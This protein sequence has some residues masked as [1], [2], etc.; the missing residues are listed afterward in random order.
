MKVKL[1][2][3]RRGVESWTGFCDNCSARIFFTADVILDSE[4]YV[5]GIEEDSDEEDEEDEECEHLGA[6]G[7]CNDPEE[8]CEYRSEDGS[9]EHP[10]RDE[11]EDAGENADDPDADED[12]P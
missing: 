7:T 11:D 8:D 12:R 5:Q 2:R 9:C 10:E 6:D 1:A 3:N 4:G